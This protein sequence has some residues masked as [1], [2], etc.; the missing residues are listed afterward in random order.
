MHRDPLKM[1]IAGGQQRN[2]FIPSLHQ[3]SVQ[4]QR[5]ILSAAPAKDEFFFIFM[6][7]LSTWFL[8]EE[9]V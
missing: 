9:P 5:G 3:Q 1:F 4:S 6:T 7:D 2:Y 8:S